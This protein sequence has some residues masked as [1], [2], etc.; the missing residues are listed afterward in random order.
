M[1]TIDNKALID[2]LIA[3]NGQ[4]QDDPPAVEIV[5]YTT[6]EG[7]IAWGVTW[8]SEHPLR[9]RRYEVETEYVR[10]P[11]VIWRAS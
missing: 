5:E 11:R 4:Y 1:A 7:R 3:N 10:N 9:H 6:P 2:E 8:A